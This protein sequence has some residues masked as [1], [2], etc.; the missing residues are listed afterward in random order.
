[1]AYQLTYVMLKPGVIQ[2]RLVG[3]IL[4]RLEDKGLELRGMKLMRIAREPAEEHYGE[5][6]GKAFYDDLI[7]YITSG[8][9][10][11]MVIGGEEAIGRVRLL[12]GATRVDEA[13]PGTIRGDFAAVTTKNIIHASDSP[14]SAQ[15]EIGLFFLESEILEYEDPNGPWTV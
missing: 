1:M 7:S 13:L 15:R 5:H 2:R 9:V 11:A 6:R 14:E 12:A 10:L 3:E 4:R 8:P